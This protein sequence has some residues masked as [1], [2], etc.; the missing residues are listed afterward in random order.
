MPSPG[1]VPLAEIL[2][3]ESVQRE[4]QLSRG[5]SPQPDADVANHSVAIRQHPHR[6]DELPNDCADERSFQS[7]A[8]AAVAG[9]VAVV[10]RLCGEIALAKLAAIEAYERASRGLIS[11]LAHEVLARELALLPSDIDALARNALEM[12]AAEE[13][14]A[15]VVSPSVAERVRAEMPLRAEPGLGDDDLWLEVRDGLVDLRLN[16]RLTNAIEQA[17]Q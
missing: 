10:E 9:R 6:I 3:A 5:A 15:V 14:V 2:R 4:A 11:S 12:F 1:F 8:E 17:L 13:P 16:V 7:S